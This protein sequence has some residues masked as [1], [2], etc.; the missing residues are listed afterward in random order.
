M[1]GLKQ[2]LLHA[3]AQAYIK[4]RRLDEADP[5]A[6]AEDYAQAMRQRRDTWPEADNPDLSITLSLTEIFRLV[7]AI[8][9]AGHY[10]EQYRKTWEAQNTWISAWQNAMAIMKDP[11]EPEW[12]KKARRAIKALHLSAPTKRARRNPEV[13]ARRY[14]Q[15]TR[16]YYDPQQNRAIEPIDQEAAIAK[17][18]TEFD[19]PTRIAAIK[20]LHRAGIRKLPRT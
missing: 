5:P 12:N 3:A 20:A 4:T 10:R 16:G 18:V 11:R 2:R 14:R 9:D 13:L 15:L 1:D 7:D 6:R 8:E 19:F 17:L